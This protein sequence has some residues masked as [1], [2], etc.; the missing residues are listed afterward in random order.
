MRRS[1]E[2]SGPYL[3]IAE[4]MPVSA[5][6]YAEIDADASAR[7]ITLN[8]SGT[9]MTVSSAAAIIADS[10]ATG[11]NAPLAVPCGT[12]TTMTANYGFPGS[13][14]ALPAFSRGR[15]RRSRINKTSTSDG[16]Q[17]TNSRK[18]PQQWQPG[19]EGHRC[20]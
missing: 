7:I 20:H 6:A 9:G 3:A 14:S 1:L 12:I 16:D 13:R 15:R 2:C 19:G 18:T 17:T 11:S 5:T 8:G 10:C 4:S